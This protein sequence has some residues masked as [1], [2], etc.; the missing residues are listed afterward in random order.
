MSD[1]IKNQ[2]LPLKR[3]MNGFLTAAHEE[4]DTLGPHAHLCDVLGKPLHGVLV[5][6]QD[7][8][9]VMKDIK[10]FHLCF[11]EIIDG[12]PET[13]HKSSIRS[14]I[15]AHEELLWAQYEIQITLDR[16]KS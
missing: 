1:A 11:I 5:L 7:T 13:K 12:L 8:N 4:L 15:K 16:F 6:C 14:Y 10:A 3:K 2:L 9:W